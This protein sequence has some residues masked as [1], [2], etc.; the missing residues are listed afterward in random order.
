MVGRDI[1]TVVMHD[2]PVKVYLEATPEERARRR[3]SELF[4]R[5][6]PAD[7]DSVLSDIVRRD[8]I[9]SSRSVAPLQVA[10]DA[11]VIDT[12]EL[13]PEQVIEE[14]LTIIQQARSDSD[15]Q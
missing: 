1:G 2:A 6:I 9:D 3:Y 4:A 14:I 10:S 11:I 8:N 5:G 7:Y 13:S 12:S 15:S